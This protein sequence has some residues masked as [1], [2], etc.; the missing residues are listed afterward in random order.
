M[1]V[2][3]RMRVRKD[4]PAL[5]DVSVL[6]AFADAYL[7]LRAAVADGV[8]GAE[9]A[10]HQL[11]VLGAVFTDMSGFTP[12]VAAAIL[13]A[14]AT[15][16]VTTMTTKLK[17]NTPQGTDPA[18][19][20]AKLMGAAR[21]KDAGDRLSRKRY[22]VKRP[23]GNPL[24]YGGAAVERPSE[25]DNALIG[26]FF[27]HRLRQQG[28][29]CELSEW[30]RSLLADSAQKD[31]WVGTLP[32]GD[33]YGGGSPGDYVPAHRVKALLDDTI[34]GGIYLNPVVLDT[35][36]ITKPLLSG[37]LFPFV[38]VKPITGRRVQVPV[39]ENLSVSW[40]TGPGTAATPFNTASLVSP[41]DTAVQNVQGFM[42]LSNDLLAD[43]PVNI[44]AAVVEL[45]GERLKSELDRVIAIGNGFNEPLGFALASGVVTVGSDG[46]GTVTVSDA[47]AMI[48][49]VPVQYRQQDWNPCFVGNDTLYRRF[50]GIQV[51]PGDERRVFGQGMMGTDETQRYQLFEY[52]FRVCNNLTN[53]KLVFGCLKRY[54]LYQRLGMEI[55]RESGGRTLALSNTSL[56]GIRARFGGRVVDGNAFAL[57]TDLPS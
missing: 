32:N 53:N 27:K 42:E 21:V 19:K 13:P 25:Y 17:A 36:V 31:A 45:F 56:V 6:P 11:T 35:A 38:D 30:E 46:G 3:K 22:E 50:R 52:K 34:S 4:A 26:T 1:R 14:R 18:T 12:A 40:G 23:D 41:L 39:I 51:G 48:F 10:L 5:T 2:L 37:Q 29:A 44:G 49:A 57:M 7:G 8:P 43:S 33:Y 47:E 20:S 15:K 9:K 55:V 16:R 28:F 24:V 54:R